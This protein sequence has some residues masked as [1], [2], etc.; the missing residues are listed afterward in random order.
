M[1]RGDKAQSGIFPKDLGTEVWPSGYG[2]QIMFRDWQVGLMSIYSR[3]IT[4]HQSL[5]ISGQ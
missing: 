5:T 4:Y 2:I 3:E 1:V